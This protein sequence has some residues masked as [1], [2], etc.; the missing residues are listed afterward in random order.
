ME[1]HNKRILRDYHFPSVVPNPADRHY[2]DVQRKD[3]LSRGNNGQLDQVRI[4][5]MLGK[6][7][8]RLRF[9]ENRVKT[10]KIVI[11]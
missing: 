7:Q 9:P 2:A 11:F 8:H 10:L 4:K 1:R 5:S 6:F 3:L